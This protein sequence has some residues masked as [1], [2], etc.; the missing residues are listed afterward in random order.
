MR[1]QYTGKKKH[2]PTQ[3]KI[4]S[5]CFLKYLKSNSNEVDKESLEHLDKNTTSDVTWT[6]ALMNQMASESRLKE[7]YAVL[8][9]KIW[10]KH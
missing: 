9:S 5:K 10:R 7:G 2:T 4:L 6:K 3:H 1:Y 8:D